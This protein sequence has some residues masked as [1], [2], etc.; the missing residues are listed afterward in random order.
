MP[1]KAPPKSVAGGY[2]LALDV[3]GHLGYSDERSDGCTDSSG[4]MFGN[5]E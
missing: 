3:S 4:F 5:G 1:T 2:I